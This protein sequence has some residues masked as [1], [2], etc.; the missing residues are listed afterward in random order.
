MV[1]PAATDTPALLH[2][3][4]FWVNQLVFGAAQLNSNVRG[5][6]V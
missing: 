6:V 3:Q 1:Y 4:V 5:G 2:S